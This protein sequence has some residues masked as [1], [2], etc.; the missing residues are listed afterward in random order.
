MVMRIGGLASGMDI[1][2]LVAKLMQAERTP[3]N[4]A[5]Q[6]KQTFEWQRDAYRNVNQATQKL[7]KFLEG[8][9]FLQSQMVKKT[10]T[11]SN[12]KLVSVNATNSATG[13][14]NIESVT[15]LATATQM[16]GRQT[17][18]TG[19]TKLSDL[20][21]AGTSLELSAID[22][23][24]NLGKAVT[25]N[26]DPNTETINGLVKKINDSNA[27]VTALFEN[28][29]LSLT[30]N[31]TGSVKSGS[32][33]IVFGSGK[34]V[35]DALGFD[36]D[37][38]VTKREGQNA[39][40]QVNGI[41][42]ERSSN[43]VNISGYEITLKETF[44]AKAGA[45]ERLAAATA[46][47]ANA[48]AALP[49]L[50]ATKSAA[51]DAYTTY[52]DNIYQ[53]AYDDLFQT[54]DLKNSY[55]TLDKKFLSE[56]TT[57]DI[58][59]LA[60]IKGKDNAEIDAAFADPT[61]S[62][63]VRNKFVGL[64]RGDLGKL[65]DLTD[66]DD[67]AQNYL[68]RF[69]DFYDIEKQNNAN[70]ATSNAA[71]AAYAAGVT[72]QDV[73]QK[74]Y[75]N[76]VAAVADTAGD[77][78]PTVVAVGI[79]ST[80]DTGA[81]KDRIKEFVEAYNGMLDTLNGLLT[82]KKYRDFPPLTNE[83]REDMSENEQ[84]LWDEK[85]KSG[86]LRNDSLIRE[87]LSKMR[88]QFMSQVE[89]LGDKTI[90]ALAEIGITTSNKMSDNGKLVIDEKKLDAALEK[91]PQQVVEMFTQRGSVTTTYDADKKRNVTVDSRGIT[92]RLRDEISALT[93]NIEKRAGRE[94]ATEQ[95]Y[96]LGRSIIDTDKQ[97]SKLQAKLQNIEARYWKQFTAMEQAINRANQQSTMF[98]PGMTQ[99]Q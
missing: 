28:G 96:N 34:E 84:K 21:I 32:G 83:Q 43:K 57:D 17:A 2:S 44:N 11:S 20:G 69:Q 67:P 19:N 89:G 25:I 92:E 23:D 1:D 45:Q 94:G 75:D 42:M 87:G 29:Q 39:I 40:L 97:I 33:E 46:E 8:N 99:Q 55:K 86:L 73:A 81:I 85:A 38:Q 64:N 49:G 91:D 47:L 98:F 51:N 90:D 53:L 18:H 13:T 50:A 70:K 78:S 54:E 5:F 76:A 6:K 35:F 12:D 26:F 79:N 4:K 62:E 14:L 95:T 41:S 82:E 24:G 68:A 3:L 7:N 48:Q 71:D 59:F 63:D 15:Q 10:A 16:V 93:K 27:G 61:L 58:D 56:L 60:S 72:R 36:D 65:A 88:T 80:T 66:Q 22:K 74:S 37:N 52:R 77:T 30:A 31:N 9:M